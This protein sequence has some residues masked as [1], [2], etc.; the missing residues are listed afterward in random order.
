MS[1]TLRLLGYGMCHR[2]QVK[3]K[4]VPVYGM[5]A[6]RES[7]RIAPLVLS[8]TLEE[9]EWSASRAGR[10]TPGNN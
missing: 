7:R 9:G 1:E 6:Y 8:L 10:F 2:V 3:G 4:A 5:Q